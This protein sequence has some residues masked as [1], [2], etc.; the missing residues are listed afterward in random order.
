MSASQC[1]LSTTL[2]A[3]VTP[4]EIKEKV[5]P[6]DLETALAA[7]VEAK[8]S[9][10]GPGRK[11]LVLVFLCSAQFFDI[12]NAVS[13]IIALPQVSLFNCLYYLFNPY[14]I[15]LDRFQMTSISLRVPFNGS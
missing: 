6:E 7:E 4:V 14:P 15:V 12:F 2:P 5:Q 13:T 3:S 9:P 10:L 1:S 11:I 8:Q